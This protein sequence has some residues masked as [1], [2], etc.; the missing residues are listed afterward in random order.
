MN[1]DDL[2]PQDSASKISFDDLIPA[3]SAEKKFGLGDTWPARLAK[4]IFS[5]VT[6][7]GDV[8]QGNVSMVGE[9]GRTNPDV[10][11][12]SAEL[13]SVASPLSPAARIGVGWAGTLKTKEGPAPTQEAL[14]TA[15]GSGY[16]KARSLGVELYPGSLSSLGEKIT[17]ALTDIGING[18]LAPKTFGILNRIKEAPADSVVTVPNLETVRRA[19]GHAA[20]DF[21]NPTEQLAAGRA[22]RDLADYLASIPDKD[23]VRGPASEVSQIIKD[24]NAN[25]AA[26]E[27]SAQVSDALKKAELQTAAT[28]SG[29]NLDNRTRQS[30]VRLLTNDKTGAG[31]TQSE[32]DAA[33]SIIKGSNT[34]DLMRSA[35]NFLGG[36]GGLGMLHGSSIG[37]A[38]GATV[39][40]PLGAAI[41]A[42]TVPALGY[43]L[44]KGADASTLNKVHAFQERV[45]KRSPLGESMPDKVVNGMTPRQAIMA[46]LIEAGFVPRVSGANE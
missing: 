11:G 16:D 29:R 3:K 18:D 35:G 30:F 42:T 26:S 2:I 10:I 25:Y 45:R 9:D 39:A 24:A 32:L 46:R 13:A 38:G 15:A 1:F 17:S 21:S 27:R 7:P 4:S 6:L 43:A 31:F 34:A 20:G 44:K 28:H 12:R 36:G 33:E 37:A 14:A 19:F 23:V 22:K 8:A 5:A 41:G 40:G